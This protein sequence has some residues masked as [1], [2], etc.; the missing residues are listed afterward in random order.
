[1]PG[2]Q[3]CR[4][5]DRELHMGIVIWLSQAYRLYPWLCLEFAAVIIL[6]AVGGFLNILFYNYYFYYF[7]VYMCVCVVGQRTANYG[8]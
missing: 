8:G 3:V 2:D 5:R 6:V 4:A 7:L 1:M